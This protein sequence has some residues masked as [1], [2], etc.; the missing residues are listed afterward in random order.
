[1]FR[2][3]IR[4]RTLLSMGVVTCALLP[5]TAIAATTTA[6]TV[7]GVV[8]SELSVAV[9]TPPTPMALTHAAAGTSA[10][11]LSIVSTTPW[12]LTI[13]DASSTTPGQMDKVNCTSSAALGGSLA[14]A[15]QWSNALDSTKSGALSGTPA[16]VATGSLVGAA[17]VN[18]SQSLG[19]SEALNAADC[20]E[21]Q[22]TFTV[23]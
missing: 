15:L 4:V 17:T 8:G 23:A 2:S 20:Y 9:S 19:A 18:F 11:A 12:T 22:A 13:H 7:S 14:N 5:A 6:P 16:T 10:A 21:L 3:P 1:M